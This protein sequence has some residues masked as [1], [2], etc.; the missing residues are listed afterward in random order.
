MNTN[1]HADTKTLR[2]FS[3]KKKKKRKNRKIEK[4]HLQRQKF[5]KVNQLELYIH[6]HKSWN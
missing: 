3:C 2:M 4:Q 5:V 6:R 1:S